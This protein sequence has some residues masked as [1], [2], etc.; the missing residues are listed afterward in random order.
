MAVDR[1]GLQYTIEVRDRFSATTQAFRKEMRASKAA[2]RDFQDSFRGN[3]QSSQ[4][5]KELADAAK[6][7]ANAQ[8]QQV[9][10]SRR[11]KKELTEEEK[12]LKRLAAEAKAQAAREREAVRIRNAQTRDSNS[13]IR[14]LSGEERALRRLREAQ[15]RVLRQRKVEEGLV[16]SG[17]KQA[18]QEKRELTAVEEA[19]R[20]VARALR[21]RAVAQQQLAILRGQGQGDLINNSLLKR[22]GELETATSRTARNAGNIFFSFRRLI[23]ILAV[24]TLARQAVSGFQQLISLGL[25]FGDSLESA[26]TSIA[27]IVLATGELRDE[28]G[29]V[30]TGAEA[31]AR[32][33]GI[34]ARQIR[35]LRQDALATTATFEQLLDTFQIAVGPGLAAGLNLD[36]IRQLSV[37]VSQAAT[38]IGL[39]QNQLAEEIRSLL[40]GTIQARTTRIATVLGISNADIRRLQE[41]GDL[42]NF[43]D[44]RFSA[45]AESAQKQARSTLAGITAL[46]QGAVGEV[47]GQAAG[48]LRDE[49]LRTLND[50]LDDVL[51]VRDELGNVAPNPRVVQAFRALFDALRVGIDRARELGESLGFE[52]L[53]DVLQAIGTGLV[54]AIE[55]VVGFA[56]GL[57]LTFTTIKSVVDEVSGALNLTARD[58]GRIAGILGSIV[59]LNVVWKNTVGLLGVG[60]K[61]VLKTL[62]KVGPTLLKFAGIGT[63]IVASI[64]LLVR[65]FTGLDV[66]IGQTISIIQLSFEELFGTVTRQGVI[67]AKTL[68]NRIVQFL[69]DPIGF[70]A[71]QFAD[72]FGTIAGGAAVLAQLGVISEETRSNVEDTIGELERI[73]AGRGQ[74]TGFRLFSE[75]NLAQD[76]QDLADF[77]DESQQKFNALEG[78][79]SGREGGAAGGVAGVGEAAK[80]AS[81]GVDEFF[82]IISTANAPIRELAESLVKLQDELLAVRTEF[83]SIENTAGL[84]GAAGNI[85]RFFTEADVANAER[86]RKLQTE[87]TQ[88]QDRILELRATSAEQ[89]GLDLEQQAEFLSLAKDLND[90]REAADLA[91]EEQLKVTQLR[92]A[93]V[94]RQELPALRQQNQV[95]ETTAAYQ[96]R[97]AAAQRGVVGVRQRELLAAQQAL[98]VAIQEEQ[99][100]SRKRDEELAFLRQTAAG[101]QGDER[102]EL[103]ALVSTLEG[104]AELEERIA[105]ARLDQLRFAQEEASL[106][107]NGTFS[108]GLREGFSDILEEL[109]TRFEQGVAI[110][111]GSV[112]QLSDFISDSIVSAFDPTDD[113]SFEEKFARFLQ[114]IAKLILN[115][116]VQLLVATAI[117]KAFGVPLPG[118]TTPPPAI[119]GV[120]DGGLVPGYAKGGKV[121]SERARP[122]LA[123]FTPGVRG[124][125]RGGRARARDPRDTVPAFLQPGEFVVRKSVVDSL[126]TGFFE[127][128]NN[129]RLTPSAT[130]VSA[131]SGAKAASAGMQSGGLV[132]DQ[133]ASSAAVAQASESGQQ[134]TPVVLPAVVA[135]EREMDRLANGGKA[136]MLNFFRENAGTINSLL[137]KNSRG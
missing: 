49:L 94:A 124:F 3:R 97:I 106:I 99:V 113:T 6:N 75:E 13:R 93:I 110:I 72:L 29:E 15:A 122:S 78:E 4:Q 56:E 82:G 25:R 71:N 123:H 84:D 88:T 34:A 53:E 32:A 40:S 18:R 9:A 85:A 132:A 121:R 1:G 136:G 96:E 73:A 22:A 61:D 107:A 7:V 92:A 37:S 42:F 101:A 100:A 87:I 8:R 41:T 14:V 91:I 35:E 46:A 11:V 90:L 16:A 126:G 28:F 129:G 109:P 51:L 86:L 120:A 112:Q 43:L 48:P 2:F 67:F 127:A 116:I 31:L 59:A 79:I 45:F 83:D 114:G 70:I 64:K 118:D 39:P 77:L 63:L 21:E 117:A 38:A 137:R 108:D 17:L 98:A 58:L 20:R 74:G 30:V 24:F 19:Q 135:K 89:G 105:Q 44:E 52:G 36:E 76:R 50:I 54:A 134:G 80:D 95:L 27:G 55:F 102:T 65:E 125:A 130:P 81:E 103:E 66:T 26:Q 33:E 133:V 69:T 111:R 60:Y 47:L 57:L 104:R 23:G 10:Q 5:L 68:A 128:V 12:L 115:Q 119:P 131:P 62:L